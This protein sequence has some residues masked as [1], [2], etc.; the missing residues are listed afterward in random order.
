MEAW[1]E[2][3]SHRAFV[4]AMHARVNGAR[5]TAP[6]LQ[7]LLPDPLLLPP[8]AV[9]GRVVAPRVGLAGGGSGPK[10]AGGCCSPRLRRGVEQ[11]SSGAAIFGQGPRGSSGARPP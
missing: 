2:V 11:L 6:A 4:R 3:P 9:A 5:T 1:R 10:P 8:Q 7:L